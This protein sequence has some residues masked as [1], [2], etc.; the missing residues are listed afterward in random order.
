MQIQK[1]AK[2]LIWVKSFNIL[3]T[4]TFFNLQK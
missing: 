2:R 1:I 4:W 3:R